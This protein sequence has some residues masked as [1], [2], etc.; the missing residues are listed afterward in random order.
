MKG[1]ET[2]TDREHVKKEFR[3]YTADY[4]INDA[5]IKLKIVHTY[6]VAEIS[7]RIALSLGLSEEDR[8]TAWLIG[9]LHDIGRF[10][11]LK[12]YN[13]FNDA[14]SFDHAAYGAGLLFDRGLIRVFMQDD[15]R[16]R[17]IHQAVACHSM[18]R[19]PEGM[20]E[21]ML[22]FV[23]I[24]RDADKADILR[25]NLETPQQEIYN[26]PAEVLVNAAITPEVLESFSEHHAVE[27]RLKKSP[28]DHLVGHAS[29]VFEL[30]FP[31]SY[32]IVKEQGYL[33]RMLDFPT[34]NPDTEKK[35]SQMKNILHEYI[36]RK[37]GE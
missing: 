12:K 8:D 13:T 10:D 35:L 32:R 24:I 19:I 16:D 7:D 22:M 29:L 27:H 11:Q 9:M 5:K 15:S 3:N 36:D 37:I 2:M 30:V 4:D 6:K 33:D 25:A 34:K 26:V 17:I 20:D 18:Y 28:I 31:E 14:A 21:R 1:N 23:N